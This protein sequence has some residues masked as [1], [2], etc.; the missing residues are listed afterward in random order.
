MEAEAPVGAG[1]CQV[2]LDNRSPLAGSFEHEV[3]SVSA[4]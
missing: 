3:K 4:R 1:M 2:Y